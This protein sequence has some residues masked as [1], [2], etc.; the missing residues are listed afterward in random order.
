MSSAHSKPEGEPPTAC[1][2]SGIRLCSVHYCA[3]PN[4]TPT[5]CGHF[6]SAIPPIPGNAKRSN[7]SALFNVFRY[8]PLAQCCTRGH[9]R[10][11]KLTELERSYQLRER[12]MAYAECTQG[13]FRAGGR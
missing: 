7:Q 9:P 10:Q 1:L 8:A 6:T 4:D 13:T 3:G 2:V 11:E 12:E 5:V